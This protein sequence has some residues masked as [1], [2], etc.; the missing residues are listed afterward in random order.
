MLPPDSRWNMREVV[1]EYRHSYLVTTVY[2][3]GK[4][5]IP[6]Q[7]LHVDAICELGILEVPQ[8]HV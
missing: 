3:G 6:Q 7:V 1:V 2:V 5:V 4:H 8:I